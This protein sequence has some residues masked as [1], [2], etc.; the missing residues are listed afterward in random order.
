MVNIENN[1]ADQLQKQCSCRVK[2]DHWA[3]VSSH[4]YTFILELWEL[5]IFTDRWT[6]LLCQFLKHPL[7]MCRLPRAYYFHFS[8]SCDLR[9]HT[10]MTSSDETT[11]TP[12]SVSDIPLSICSLFILSPYLS[13]CYYTVCCSFPLNLTAQSKQVC[14]GTGNVYFGNVIVPPVVFSKTTDMF[15]VI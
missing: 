5:R 12:F 2:Y 1:R 14:R 9:V 13:F 6:E 7:E 3:I 11:V 4:I 15:I 10:R 8:L